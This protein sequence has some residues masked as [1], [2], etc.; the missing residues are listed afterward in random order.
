MAAARMTM[1]AA[2]GHILFL[3]ASSAA[4]T[5]EAAAY[6]SSLAGIV[7]FS[8]MDLYLPGINAII[9]PRE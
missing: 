1:A 6:L 4:L 8:A 7:H 9:L 5:S 2:K 3:D